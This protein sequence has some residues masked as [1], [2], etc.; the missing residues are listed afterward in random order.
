MR[1]LH[2]SWVEKDDIFKSII[3]YKHD[4]PGCDLIF[5]LRYQIE[6]ETNKTM[7]SWDEMYDG[8]YHAITT[9]LTELAC[10]TVNLILYGQNNKTAENNHGLWINPRIVR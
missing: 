3:G 1:A 7:K 8:K 2:G 10:Y 6:D 9:V 5:E 4:S